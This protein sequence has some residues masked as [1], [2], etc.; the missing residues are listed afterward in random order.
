M[1]F[2]ACLSQLS[3]VGMMSRVV[4]AN[5]SR[6]ILD[7]YILSWGTLAVMVLKWS[8]E[9]TYFWTA[10]FLWRFIEYTSII[11]Y[12]RIFRAGFPQRL[13]ADPARAYLGYRAIIIDVVNYIQF[14][15][16][17]AVVYWGNRMYFSPKITSAFDAVYFS[18]VTMATVG[19]G[20]ITPLGCM[21]VV[22]LVQILFGIFMI[23]IIVG[24]LLGQRVLYPESEQSS[25]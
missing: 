21:R 23:A 13:E 9:E 20:D 3:P 16:M 5:Y 6:L 17:F 4:S 1:Y 18:I 22:A 10:L 19:Y 24:V 14:A 8:A 7:T 15:L 25:D 2:Y 11:I 12:Q